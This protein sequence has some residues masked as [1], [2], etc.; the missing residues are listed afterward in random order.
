MWFR[1]DLPARQLVDHVRGRLTPFKV[2][3][4]VHLADDLP[5]NASGKVLKRL[6]CDQFSG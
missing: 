6:L 1:C 4:W 5:Q 3:K 2:P